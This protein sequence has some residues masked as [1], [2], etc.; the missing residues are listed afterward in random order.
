MTSE[1]LDEKTGNIT[2]QNGTMTISIP[3]DWCPI[4]KITEETIVTKK[5]M[6]GKHGYFMAIHSNEEKK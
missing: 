6:N 2:N 5:L 3:A 4:L 1:Q